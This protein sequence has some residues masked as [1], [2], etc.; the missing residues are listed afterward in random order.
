MSADTRPISPARFAAAL[1]DLAPPLL[2]LKVLEIRNSIAHLEYSND[3]LRPFADGTATATAMAT[4][5]GPGSGGAAVPQQP[6]QDCVDAIR[7]NEA[8]MARMAQRIELVRAEVER[9]GM[10]W[11]EFQTGEDMVAAAQADHAQRRHNGRV[12]DAPQRPEEGEGEASTNGG[13]HAA[14]TD[15][16]FQTGTV[17]LSSPSR[18][19]VGGR[20]TDDELRRGIE[21]TMRD[22]GGEED[23]GLHL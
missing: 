6:D 11:A 15:G 18:S 12:A 5:P 22:L 1:Q 13:V 20:L 16:T 19:G 21:Q 14:W 8:V 3:Q 2:H 4:P 23:G 10:S 17:S 7:E 9:R